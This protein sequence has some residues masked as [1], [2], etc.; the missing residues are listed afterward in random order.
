MENEILAPVTEQKAK[1]DLPLVEVKDVSMRF[2]MPTEKIDNVKEFFI[3]L[4]QRKLKYEDFWVLKNI[5]FE[6]HRG[7]SVGILGRNGAGKSTLL[8]LISG[9]VEPTSGSIRVRGSIVPLLKLGAGFDMNATGKENVFLNGAI[10]GFS[11]K[12]MQARYDSIVE[13]SELGRFMNMPLKN[14]SSGM[15]T[16]LGFSI[17]VD[18]NPDLLI[19]DEILAVGDAPFQKKCADKIEQLQKNGTTLLLVSHSAPQ[20]KKLCKTALWI[21]DGEI[22]LYDEAEKVSDAYAADC[23]HQ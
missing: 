7:E 6:I 9:I 19:I 8:K 10:M 4:V 15:L 2:R 1:S 12:E 21:K 22:V 23:N 13:F 17:A 11:K 5:S 18:V 16:R 20:V 14:Y 3:K